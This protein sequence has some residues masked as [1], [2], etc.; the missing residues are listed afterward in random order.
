M[1]FLFV[2]MMTLMLTSVF[3][4]NHNHYGVQSA[5][6]EVHAEA[7]NKFRLT[8]D[9]KVR[10]DKITSM[11]KEA[12]KS[13]ND[14]KVLAVYGTRMTETVD[15]I[16]KTCKLE[17]AADVAIH[18]YLALIYEGAAELKNGKFDNG[19]AKIHKALMSYEKLFSLK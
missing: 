3:A 1:K 7:N 4:Q 15:E 16:F 18:P 8:E 19:H 9:L 17:P 10:M 2:A 13:K 14:S 5:K 12:M 11:M 6:N